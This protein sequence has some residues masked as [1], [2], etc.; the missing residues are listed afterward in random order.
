M[1]FPL[2]RYAHVNDDLPRRAARPKPREGVLDARIGEGDDCGER[3]PEASLL[4][5]ISYDFQVSCRAPWVDPKQ[6][7]GTEEQIETRQ[8]LDTGGYP[9]RRVSADRDVVMWPGWM[10]MDDGRLAGGWT[11]DR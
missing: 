3:R 6:L 10:W 11:V 4:H 1:S 2:L 8:T 5:S 9:G 7:A